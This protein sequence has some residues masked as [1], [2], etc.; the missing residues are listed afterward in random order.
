MVVRPNRASATR[1]GTRRAAEGENAVF[2]S[3]T[4]QVT[5]LGDTGSDTG[6]D[7]LWL[8]AGL[9][10]MCDFAMVAHMVGLF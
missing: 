10:W 2:A 7:P 3:S 1:A 4:T 8:L 5:A 6:L 9:L